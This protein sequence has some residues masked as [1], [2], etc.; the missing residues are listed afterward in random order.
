MSAQQILQNYDSIRQALPSAKPD[1]V[2]DYAAMKDNIN[3]LFKGLSPQFGTGSPEG[4]ITATASLV[5]YD[6]ALSPVS[7]TGYFND[8]IG[9]NTGW[10]PIV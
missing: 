2:A 7:V 1:F 5:Y 8:T 6:V 4:V 3:E 9:L 10:V